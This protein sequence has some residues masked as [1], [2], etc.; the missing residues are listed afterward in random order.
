MLTTQSAIYTISASIDLTIW[1]LNCHFRNVQIPSI[2][3]NFMLVC[4]LLR[5]KTMFHIKLII[6]GPPRIIGGSCVM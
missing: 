4:L 3:L 1:S 5:E 2:H 6:W